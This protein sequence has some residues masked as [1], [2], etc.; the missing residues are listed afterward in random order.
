MLEN[1]VLGYGKVMQKKI[2]RQIFLLFSAFEAIF[3]IS[4]FIHVIS[5]TSFISPLKPF[6]FISGMIE[7]PPFSDILTMESM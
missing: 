1:P 2:K 7:T 4:H 5:I 3:Q 6:V